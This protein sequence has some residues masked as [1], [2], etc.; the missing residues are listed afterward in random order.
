[1]HA[2]VCVCVFVR[3]RERERVGAIFVVESPICEMSMFGDN[4]YEKVFLTL[5]FL[6]VYT[7]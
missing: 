1:M 2:F 5:T 4:K 6:R 7:L 3:E